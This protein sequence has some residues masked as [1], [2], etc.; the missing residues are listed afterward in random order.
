MESCPATH[1]NAARWFAMR[2]DDEVRVRRQ[3]SGKRAGTKVLTQEYWADLECYLLR[4]FRWRATSTAD[5]P[6]RTAPARVGGWAA[7]L[8]RLRAASQSLRVVHWTAED[9]AKPHPTRRATL[10]DDLRGSGHCC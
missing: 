2:R 6:R 8:N 9:R 4:L 5:S 1:A 10:A 3:T 7:R